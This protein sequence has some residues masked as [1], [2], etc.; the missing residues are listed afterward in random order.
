MANT[1]LNNEILKAFFS[2]VVGRRKISLLS[3]LLINIGLEVLAGVIWEEKEIQYGRQSNPDDLHTPD[4]VNMLLY[5][6]KG[7]L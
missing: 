6:A 1:I 3:F 4:P 2:I 7:T 5:V